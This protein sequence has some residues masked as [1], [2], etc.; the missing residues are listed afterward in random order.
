MRPKVFKGYV[1]LWLETTLNK[2]Q[3]FVAIFAHSAT[4]LM[5][6]VW[7]HLWPS[8]GHGANRTSELALPRGFRFCYTRNRSVK[9]WGN[10][11]LFL[12]QFW[13]FPILLNL[14]RK[15]GFKGPNKARNGLN[16]ALSSQFSASNSAKLKRK[17]GKI[18]QYFNCFK[19]QQSGF[20]YSKT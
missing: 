11:M 6:Y 13:E 2:F 4:L 15:T 8:Y 1:V 14:M 18:K 7:N 10:S 17:G 19:F 5:R 12:F 3:F 20:V 16:L 9:T